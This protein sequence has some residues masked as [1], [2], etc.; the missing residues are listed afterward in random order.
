MSGKAC[1]CLKRPVCVRTSQRKPLTPGRIR[2]RPVDGEPSKSLLFQKGIDPMFYLK[3]V[4]HVCCMLRLFSTHLAPL[5]K[6][7]FR[8]EY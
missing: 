1:H 7:F 2:G 4:K 5:S 3:E 6:G 8:Q